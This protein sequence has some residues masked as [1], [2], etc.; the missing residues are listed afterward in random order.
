[1][2]AT[3][4]VTCRECGYAKP[5]RKPCPNPQCFAG[6]RAFDRAF[7]KWNNAKE[8]YITAAL[9]KLPAGV[10]V[11]ARSIEDQYEREHPKPVA[12]DYERR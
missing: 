2:S 1:M 12:S 11:I 8:A 6:R 9:A 7:R 3:K 5:A 4:Y 10:R